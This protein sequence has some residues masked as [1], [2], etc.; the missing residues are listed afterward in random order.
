MG[1]HVLVGQS[2]G[3]T[4]AINASLAGVYAAAKEA[5][6]DKIY[7]MVNG[8]QGL[9][10]EK[11]LD[12]RAEFPEELH[13]ELLKR[14][15]S[16]FLGSCRYKLK[17]AAAAKEDYETIFS[18]L[19]KYQ[20]S[21]FLYIGGNDSMD[22]IKKLSNYAEEIGSSIRFVGVPKT[23][24]NDL[25]GTDHTPGFGS[26]AK[27]IATTMK[28]LIRDALVYDMDC[29]TIVEIMG[30]NAGWL[31]ASAAL[32]SGPDC[33]GADLIYLPERVFDMD[34]FV[35]K[36]AQLQK[37]KRS[38]VLAVSE[39]LRLADGSYVCESG[40]TGVD[41]F[42]HKNLSGTGAVLASVLKDRLGCKTRAVELNILQRSAAHISS[43]TDINEA[44]MAGY[45][46]VEAAKRGESGVMIG[47]ERLPGENYVCKTA[48]FDV[49]HI[50]NAEKKI[51]EHFIADCGTNVSEACLQYMRPLIM[52]ELSQ[53]MV[54]G[55]PRHIVRNGIY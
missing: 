40:S 28:E 2:G 44:F 13:L 55:L 30:R 45:A 19:Q 46:A 47:F 29:V 1:F 41:A 23:I 14:T 49:N 32:S 21:L 35:E 38:L 6:A 11:L 53:I 20:I 7:G 4:A 54:N 16:S 51:P 39:G 8:I 25:V 43:A 34:A 50:A 22:T 31:T 36:V 18:I 37:T 27:Y 10:E 15:P 17:E 33:E 24:D 3:P 5:G 52:G 48:V 42:G 12:L 26:A 9:L